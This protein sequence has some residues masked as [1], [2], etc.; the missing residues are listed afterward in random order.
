[1]A[2]DCI[3]IFI[4]RLVL[5]VL[6]FHINGI[7]VCYVVFYVI[8]ILML[9]NI[10]MHEYTTICYLFSVEGHKCCI[11]LGVIMNNIVINILIK[12]FLQIYFFI[13]LEW[14]SRSRIAGLYNKCILNYIRNQQIVLQCDCSILY[15]NLG[16]F[17]SFHM[18]TNFL[19]LWNTFYQ[20]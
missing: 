17:Q 10:L 6:E 18:V 1:M 11:Y 19:D 5:S 7:M 9:N 2:H 4:S 15:Y 14:I 16:E 8:Y 13:S 3:L 12:N 20:F